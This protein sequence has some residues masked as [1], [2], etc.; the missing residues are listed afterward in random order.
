M[1]LQGGAECVTNIFSCQRLVYFTENN[2][3]S[4]SLET[5]IAFSGERQ[6]M[7][8]FSEE[9]FYDLQALNAQR[10]SDSSRA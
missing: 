4:R 1:K 8:P 3:P 9:I 7:P 10:A 2:L 6:V 5:V